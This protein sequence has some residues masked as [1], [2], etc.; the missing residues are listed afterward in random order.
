MT[1]LS[2]FF[3]CSLDAPVILGLKLTSK[4]KYLPSAF[5]RAS[6]RIGALISRC[7]ARWQHSPLWFEMWMES[8]HQDTRHLGSTCIV[9][10]PNENTDLIPQWLHLF[11]GCPS[12]I[13]IQ[14]RGKV[15]YMLV[16]IINE[17][18]AWHCGWDTFACADESLPQLQ[19][20]PNLYT[21][22]EF[23]CFP[24]LGFFNQF[25]MEIEVWLWHNFQCTNNRRVFFLTCRI[26][27]PSK[28][29]IESRRETHM[30]NFQG[31]A[32]WWWILL[33]HNNTFVLLHETHNFLFFLLRQPRRIHKDGRQRLGWVTLTDFDCSSAHSNL[34]RED[35]S[36]GTALRCCLTV[37]REGERKVL[38]Y[39]TS[40]EG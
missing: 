19:F 11:V 31:L 14:Y 37:Q 5:W 25:G 26:L 35:C 21:F 34:R 16:V 4:M 6:R 24:H 38:Q 29:R 30:P 12:P 39:S 22:T 18:T 3:L 1:R 32:F 10:F 17:T 13:S 36:Q 40:S 8:N 28:G 7:R 33:H 9:P 2:C 20:L 15:M 27:L 23:W